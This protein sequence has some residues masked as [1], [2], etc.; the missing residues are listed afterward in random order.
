M[1]IFKKILF[2]I[3]GT[4]SPEKVLPHVKTMMNLCDAELHIVYVA[5]KNEFYAEDK[6]KSGQRIKITDLVKQF[7]NEHFSD[8][9]DK[10][11]TDALDGEIEIE[12]LNYIDKKEI[13]LVIMASSSKTALG[14]TIFGSVPGKLLFDGR[15][16]VY[17]AHPQKDKFINQ[18]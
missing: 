11:V 3:D 15:V 2:P 6:N 16:P 14:K 9:V 4:K 18:V 13:D 12:L 7:R 8:K 17:L 1:L 5:K 10:V